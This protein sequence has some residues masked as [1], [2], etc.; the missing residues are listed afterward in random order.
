MLSKLAVY[1][2]DEHPPKKAKTNNTP[3]ADS[4]ADA[5]EIAVRRFEQVH[6]PL[7]AG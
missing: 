6:P 5:M 2:D 7:R 3:A 1:G 4:K